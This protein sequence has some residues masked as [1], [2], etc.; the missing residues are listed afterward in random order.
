MIQMELNEFII[1]VIESKDSG[2]H[3]YTYSLIL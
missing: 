1:I 2:N 3:S